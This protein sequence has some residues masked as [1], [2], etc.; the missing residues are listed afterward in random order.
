M[1]RCA[2]NVPS[3]KITLT[4]FV[5]DIQGQL[6]SHIEIYSVGWA[7]ALFIINGFVT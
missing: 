6:P 3:F 7:V 4:F 5:V 2:R 1:P